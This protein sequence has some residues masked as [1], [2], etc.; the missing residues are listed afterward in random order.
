VTQKLKSSFIFLTACIAASISALGTLPYGYAFAQAIDPSNSLLAVGLGLILAISAALANVV[1]GVYSLLVFY[2][3]KASTADNYLKGVSFI[4]AIPM[5]CMGYFAYYSL[6]P[7]SLTLFITIAIILINTAIAY[8]AVVNFLS[9]T[10]AWKKS[11]QAKGEFLSRS[12]GFLI[13]ILV[14]L[15]AYMAAILGFIELLEHSSLVLEK[16][17]CFKLS[18]I[19]GFISWLPFAFLYSNATQGTAYH[20]YHFCKNIHLQSEALKLKTLLLLLFSFL[21]GAAFAQMALAFFNPDFNIPVF[22]KQTSI[23]SFIHYGLVPLAYFS[24]MAV[25]YTALKNLSALR[26]S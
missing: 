23:Q 5:G 22:F 25:N 8:T 12:T 9:E 18:C 14:S 13:G 11:L 21:S 10:Q 19:L 2:R 26:H 24:S 7:Y 20:I 4:A 3:R 15:T 1:L 6:L 16:E 17:T